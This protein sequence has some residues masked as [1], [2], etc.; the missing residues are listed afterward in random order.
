MSVGDNIWT[1]TKNIPILLVA[2]AL[3]I[4]VNR[5]K[6]MCFGNH[7]TKSPSLS[8]SPEKNLWHCF[9]CGLGGSN[10]EL[11]S[12]VQGVSHIDAARWLDQMFIQTKSYLT[13]KTRAPKSNKKAEIIPEYVADTDVYK[14]LLSLAKL[15]SSGRQYLEVQRG[16]NNDTIERFHIGQ[17]SNPRYVSGKLLDKWGVERLLSCGLFKTTEQGTKFIWWDEVL[18]F[19]FFDIHQNIIYI[20]AR[21]LNG[22]DPKYVNLSK[23]KKPLFNAQILDP[24][25]AQSKIY[26]CEGI[27]DTIA[28]S[29]CGMNAVGLLGANSFNP[30]WVNLFI[31]YEIYVIPDADIAGNKMFK[32][33]QKSFRSVG[34]SVEA[35][36]IEDGKDFSDVFRLFE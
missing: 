15:Q 10:I 19:P 14:D 12:N 21:R 9:G 2:Q 13:A 31:P 4:E 25:P 8:F 3:H 16:F 28:A 33:I 27:P 22:T 35:L 6:A 36:I 30:E 1:T 24:L 18:L 23:I 32:S 29:Q 20:Q 26:I 17:I 7:D 34:K 11:V 5:N